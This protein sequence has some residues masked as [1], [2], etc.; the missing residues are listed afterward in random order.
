MSEEIRKASSDQP[1]LSVHQEPNYS[2]SIILSGITAGAGN[3]VHKMCDIKCHIIP[4]HSFSR[5]WPWAARSLAWS[6]QRGLLAP[7]SAS[8]SLD[9]APGS[10]GNM[11]LTES[12][13][14]WS[15]FHNK[16][17]HFN[18]FQD[19]IKFTTVRDHYHYSQDLSITLNRNSVISLL[20]NKLIK[21]FFHLQQDKR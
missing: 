19:S 7:R 18:H 21:K 9:N 3:C 4:G 16:I 2:Q 6:S 11:Y 5:C 15:L 20:F 1:V 13:F 10:T 8:L 12:D 14:F 17:C